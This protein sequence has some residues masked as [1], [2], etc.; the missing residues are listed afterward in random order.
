MSQPLPVVEII[1]NSCNTVFL[2]LLLC[3]YVSFIL[4]IFANTSCLIVLIGLNFVIAGIGQNAGRKTTAPKG[5]RLDLH[6]AR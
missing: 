2:L 6:E 1:S 4:H 3:N 5:G